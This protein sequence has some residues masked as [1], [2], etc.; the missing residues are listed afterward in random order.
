MDINTLYTKF[1]QHD[2]AITQLQEDI[3]QQQTDAIQHDHNGNNSTV[4]PFLNI[5]QKKFWVVH[6]LYGTA[7]ATAGNYSQFFI[8]PAACVIT[9]FQESHTTAGSDTSA[10]TLQLEKLVS[11]IAPGSGLAVLATP[12]SLKTTA[13]VPQT[14]AFPVTPGN[15][16]L[17]LGD[18]LALLLAGTPTSVA[19]LTVNLELT[20]V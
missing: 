1:Q 9:G 8:C 17:V 11:T 7:P 6:T 15:R 19:N 12:L 5:K 16:S 20:L 18:R 10:V 4:V 14:G 2:Q 13:N 3:S